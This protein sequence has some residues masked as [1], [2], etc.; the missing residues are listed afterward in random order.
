MVVAE[1]CAHNP[2]S[3][4]TAS[5]RSCSCA[6]QG[7]SRRVFASVA[8]AVSAQTRVIFRVERWGGGGHRSGGGA[9]GGR[10]GGG[11]ERG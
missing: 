6:Q 7:L 11:R 9:E 1:S 4:P 8:S 3:T 2:F 10:G 5:P